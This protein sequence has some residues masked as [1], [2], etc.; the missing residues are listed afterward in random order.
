MSLELLSS[1]GLTGAGESFKMVHLRAGKLVLTI[2][3]RPLFLLDPS[4]GGFSVLTTRQLT[5]PRVGDPKESKGEFAM[6]FITWP[7]KL[8]TVIP[9]ISYL[10]SR[11]SSIQGEKGLLKDV[12]TR[13]PTVGHG[14][15]WL[16]H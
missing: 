2:G 6:S 15:G 7:W 8:H 3:R 11:I 16:P 5:S 10:L 4:I 9:A 14:G 1:E 12:N 13:R